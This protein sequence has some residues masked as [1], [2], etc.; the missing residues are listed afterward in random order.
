MSNSW[1]FSVF[2]NSSPILNPIEVIGF[3]EVFKTNLRCDFSS[4]TRFP[5]P[6]SVTFLLTKF[7][8]LFFGPNG[9]NCFIILYNLGVISLM[10]ISKSTSISAICC[11]SVIEEETT[12]SNSAT[13]ESIFCFFIVSPAAYLWPPN[14][15]NKCSHFN[16]ASYKSNPFTDRAEPV[17][18][19]SFSESTIVGL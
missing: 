5:F 16:N 10:S 2:I 1:L 6:E 8:I 11:S 13:N 12:F 4:P 19:W 14:F 17:N 15:S 7:G 18:S 9:A 3:V